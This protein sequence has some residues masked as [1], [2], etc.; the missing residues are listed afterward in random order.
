MSRA[1]LRS[2]IRFFENQWILFRRPT[3]IFHFLPDFQEV[4][5]TQ[6]MW[7]N[8][9]L[10]KA[11]IW[12][13]T[14]QPFDTP[15]SNRPGAQVKVFSSTRALPQSLIIST[16]LDLNATQ[17]FSYFSQKK[18]GCV[19]CLIV[20]IVSVSFYVHR[21]AQFQSREVH[22]RTCFLYI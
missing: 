11:R 5:G 12:P 17:I 2:P 4:P 6:I 21:W 20:L 15:E 10:K 7:G 22:R 13:D 3:L 1:I 19:S 14:A 8:F 18:I 9:F 16:P